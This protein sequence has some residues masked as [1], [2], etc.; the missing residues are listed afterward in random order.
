MQ[1]GFFIMTGTGP[2][3]IVLAFLLNLNLEQDLYFFPHIGCDLTPSKII[4][5]EVL[6][7]LKSAAELPRL[8]CQDFSPDLSRDLRVSGLELG[9][10]FS[11]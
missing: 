5:D 11:L 6:V 3:T 8:G 10:C 1:I 4:M 2:K 9:L 7:S